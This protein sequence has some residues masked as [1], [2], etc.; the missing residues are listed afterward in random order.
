MAIRPYLERRERVFH[1]IARDIYLNPILDM[2]KQFAQ[3]VLALSLV[4]FGSASCEIIEPFDP[5]GHGGGNGG[6]QTDI[7]SGEA[8]V[9][10]ETTIEGVSF[11]GLETATGRRF[12]PLNLAEELQHDGLKIKFE[13]RLAKDYGSYYYYGEGLELTRAEPIR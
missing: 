9:H 8:T 3:L 13:G 10:F 6:G 2:K 5:P 1:A 11:Y 4:S 7:I 12:E